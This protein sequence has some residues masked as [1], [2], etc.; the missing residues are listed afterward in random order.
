M[1]YT[2]KQNCDRLM[3]TV[4]S[5][6]FMVSLR[7]ASWLEDLGRQRSVVRLLVPATSAWRCFNLILFAMTGADVTESSR[8]LNDTFSL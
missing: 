8:C 6:I 3:Y 1:G 4:T 2:A 5:V 7:V